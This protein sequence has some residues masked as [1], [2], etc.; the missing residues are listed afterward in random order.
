MP[1]PRVHVSGVAAFAALGLLLIGDLEVRAER[2]VQVSTSRALADALAD[3]GPGDIIRIAP[4]EYRGGLHCGTLQG[5][6]DAP[7][8]IEAAD[9]ADPPVIRGGGNCLHLSNPA[10]VALR[11]LVLT[12]AEGNGLN[13]DDGET[14]DSP[15]HHLTLSGLDVHDIGPAG[16]RDGLKLSGVDDFR[17][18]DC[19]FARWGDGGSAIDM[20]GC[21]GG[22]VAGCVF[23]EGADGSN[24][25]QAKGGSLDIV[26]RRCRFENAGGRGI[27]IG[28]S[29]GLAYFRPEPQGYEARDITVED[30]TFIGSMAPIAFVGVDGAVVRHNTIYRPTRW[31]LRILQENQ[32]AAFVACRNGRFERNIVAFRSDEVRTA[33]NVGGGTSPETFTFAGNVWY[34][35]DRPE[36]T[37]RLVQLPVRESGGF[38]GVNPMFADAESGNLQIGERAVQ[39]A[40]VRVDP[41]TP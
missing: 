16:N 27:N 35:L 7:I 2:V 22:V 20:V 33:V 34:C 17:I 5:A 13:I 41:T 10:H 14:K 3:A 24:G 32:D 19:R 6:D 29:T 9:P 36:Q 1:V 26:I 11:N 38:Y 21:H 37:T 8:I 4:G 30:C 15:A 23:R 31:L 39:Q 40:G 28:G 18:E 12:G 25:V